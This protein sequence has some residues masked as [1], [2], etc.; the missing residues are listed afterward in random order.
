[1]SGRRT[2]TAGDLV[3]RLTTTYREA[4]DPQLAP[5]MVAYMRGQFPYL[6]IPTPARRQLDR[7]VRSGLGPMSVDDLVDVVER[8]W[9]LAEREFQYFGAE[10]LERHVRA[11]PPEF[12]D[13]VE[14]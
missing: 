6:G 3:S 14:A 8:C 11:L 4:A 1:V 13:H 5:A 9:K 10:H 12:I 7:H 2:S